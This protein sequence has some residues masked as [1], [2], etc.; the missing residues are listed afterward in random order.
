M[1]PVVFCACRAH[2]PDHPFGLSFFHAVESVFV[3]GAPWL[4]TSFPEKRGQRE[5]MD[6]WS[7]GAV[8]AALFPQCAL[9]GDRS[10]PHQRKE[11]L[12][13]RNDLHHRPLDVGV[14]AAPRG[15]RTAGASFR[16]I[17]PLYCSSEPPGKKGEN[18]VGCFYCSRWRTERIRDL[19]WPVF[20]GQF[21]GYPPSGVPV[22]KA[23]GWN[24]KVRS[25]FFPAHGRMCAVPLFDIL[26]LFSF[27]P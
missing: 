20:A 9:Y 19:Y 5:E 16:P 24:D 3:A 15:R 17:F 4:R 10:A 18:G 7:V 12:H 25:R 23:L 26:W 11:I 6:G 8:V 2:L 21:M 1:Q 27:R 22:F 13:P 14:G